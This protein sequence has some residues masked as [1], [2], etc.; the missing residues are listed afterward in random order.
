MQ[1]SSPCLYYYLAQL[2]LF[3]VYRCWSDLSC[4]LQLERNA[5]AQLST[6]TGKRKHIA[7][8]LCSL[9]W[10]PVQFRDHIKA[11]YLFGNLYMVSPCPTS[12]L[13]F[14]L[15]VAP[16]WILNTCCLLFRHFIVQHL[17]QWLLLFS[18]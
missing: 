14:S 11:L 9:H 1:S 12:P 4:C 5:A 7:P 3:S 8:V 18:K 16:G 10:L 6:A 15:Q 2:M 13:P 17:G